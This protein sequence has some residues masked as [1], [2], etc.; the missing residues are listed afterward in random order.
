M[1]SMFG[2]KIRHLATKIIFKFDIR[3][4]SRVISVKCRI[5]IVVHVQNEFLHLVDL[6]F[7][8]NVMNLVFTLVNL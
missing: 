7:D 5:R 3:S 1:I 2:K 8:S 4:I 6:Q